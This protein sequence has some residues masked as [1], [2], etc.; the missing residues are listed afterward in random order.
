MGLIDVDLCNYSLSAGE[1]KKSR[2]S[3]NLAAAAAAGGSGGCH[4]NDD[5]ARRVPASP[6]RDMQNDEEAQFVAAVDEMRVSP[7]ISR[8]GYLHFLEESA[9]GWVKLWVV[10]THH[11]T[12]LS[13]CL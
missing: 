5:D 11:A 4:G 2:S 1:P 9:N 7:V 13:D 3:D 8:R 12:P 10:S 6:Y